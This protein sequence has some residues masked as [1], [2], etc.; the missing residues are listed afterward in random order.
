MLTIMI[1]NSYHC[2]YV[3]NEHHINGNGH[4][5]DIAMLMMIK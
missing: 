3:D 2:Y 5:N 1:V 4:Y